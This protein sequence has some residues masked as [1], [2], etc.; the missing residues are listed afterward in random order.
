MSNFLLYSIGLFYF[1]FNICDRVFACTDLD[2]IQEQVTVGATITDNFNSLDTDLLNQFL[3]IRIDGI[4][5][6][7]LIKVSFMGSRVTKGKKLIEFPCSEYLFCFIPEPLWFIDN[8]YWPCPLDDI[9]RP[10]TL[11]CIQLL[12][13]LSGFLAG[14]SECLVIHDDHFNI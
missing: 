2:S 4:Q 14:G 7:D 1:Q 5:P 12:I 3:I 13:Y 6:I 8:E 9:D 10:F 11:K